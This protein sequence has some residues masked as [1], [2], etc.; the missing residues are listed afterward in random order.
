MASHDD[1]TAEELL[2]S[3]ETMPRAAC[4]IH[5]IAL[6][7]RYVLESY[8]EVI[9]MREDAENAQTLLHLTAFVDFPSIK[10]RVMSRFSIAAAAILAVEEW[11]DAHVEASEKEK[12]Q[13]SGAPAFSVNGI[14][15]SQLPP[16]LRA[17]FE[18]PQQ[19]GEGEQNK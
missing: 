10:R 19:G 18:P 1:K 7:E 16:G 15:V 6:G 9:K 13:H 14:P 5:A 12:S 4:S 17:L 3:A 8:D 11:S 2:R